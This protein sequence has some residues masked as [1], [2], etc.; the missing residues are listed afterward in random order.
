VEYGAEMLVRQEEH[1]PASHDY[2]VS[3][4][5][6]TVFEP[7]GLP[8]GWKA[9]SVSSAGGVRERTADVARRQRRGV[10]RVRHDVGAGADSLHVRDER[11]V[12]VL[13]VAVGPSDGRLEQPE[14]TVERRTSRRRMSW[15]TL[16]DCTEVVGSWNG[17]E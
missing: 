4:D 3:D 1:V 17:P 16:I 2:E 14:L 12:D 13:V 15:M 6:S 8:V 10:L 9:L 7:V 5:W 11:S